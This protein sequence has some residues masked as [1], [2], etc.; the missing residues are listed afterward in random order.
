MTAE[1]TPEPLPVVV[2]NPTPDDAPFWEAAAHDRFILPRC[3]GC[4]T[5]IW[6]PRSFCPDCHTTDVEWVNVSGRGTVYSFTVNQRGPGAWAEHSPFVIA[7]VE[8]EEGP[9]IL[10][11]IVGS[12]PAQVHIGQAVTAVFEPAGTTKVIR[13]TPV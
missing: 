9:R 6:Y 13:F 2:P 5:Y 7:Y 4:A 11:N 8:L 12:D 10:T 3:R 1:T